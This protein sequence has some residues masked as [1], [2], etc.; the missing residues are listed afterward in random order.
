MQMTADRFCDSTAHLQTTNPTPS[1]RKHRRIFL[2]NEPLLSWLNHCFDFHNNF[3]K[4]F[5]K[6]ARPR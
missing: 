2:P 4:G 5:I 1:K 6:D 3:S